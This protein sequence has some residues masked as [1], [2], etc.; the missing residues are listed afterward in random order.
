MTIESDRRLKHLRSIRR[1]Y[2]T[3]LRVSGGKRPTNYAKMRTFTVG[4]MAIVDEETRSGGFGPTLKFPGASSVPKN[5]G[6]VRARTTVSKSK[7]KKPSTK[8]M[9][10]AA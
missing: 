1:R 4:L 7:T 2:D 5:K 6:K 10:E 8:A 9:A 3:L